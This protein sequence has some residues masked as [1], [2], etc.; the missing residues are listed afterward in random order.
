MAPMKYSCPECFDQDFAFKKA[1]Q[2]GVERGRIAL[3]VLA[4]V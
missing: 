3:H 1:R 2:K 4:P